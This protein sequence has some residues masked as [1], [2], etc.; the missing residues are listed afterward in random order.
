MSKVEC[1]LCA[2]C[3]H[4]QDGGS[5]G[6]TAKVLGK[7][8]IV[9]LEYDCHEWSEGG[10][11]VLKPEF[12]HL[13]AFTKDASDYSAILMTAPDFGCVQYEETLK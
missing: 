2:T 11:N 7:C 13:K 8:R 4:W 3:K 10:K 9:P 1:G 6:K 5:Y 12:A